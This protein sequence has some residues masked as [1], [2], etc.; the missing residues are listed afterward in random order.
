MSVVVIQ[1]GVKTL[2]SLLFVGKVKLKPLSWL[3][4][5]I[6]WIFFFLKDL[7]SVF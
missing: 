6:S 2:W 3:S 1:L 7:C 5:L 4:I